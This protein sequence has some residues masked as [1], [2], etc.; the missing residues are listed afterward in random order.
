MRFILP[1]DSE[2]LPKHGSN[3][4]VNDQLMIK[5]SEIHWKLSAESLI[6]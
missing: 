2:E 3:D 5:K 6:G 1:A 4:T